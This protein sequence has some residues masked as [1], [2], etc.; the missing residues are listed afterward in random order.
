MNDKRAV[1]KTS[2]FS[3]VATLIFCFVMLIVGI[4][5]L[6]GILPDEPL[7]VIF[8]ILWMIFCIGG[9]IYSIIV[10]VSYSNDE[11]K[12][13]SLI[14]TDVIDIKDKDNEKVMDFDERLRKLESLKKDHLITEE[15]YRLKREEIF[16]EKW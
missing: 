12:D 7:A 4:V 14:A 10:L 2:P 13:I 11:N 5:F 6:K 1:V 16:K 15:E 8:M 9:I 3:A